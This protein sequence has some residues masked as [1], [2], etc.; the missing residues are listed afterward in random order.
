MIL[1]NIKYRSRYENIHPLFKRGF[2]F[3]EQNDLDQLPNG[4]NEID[5]EN[6]FAIVSRNGNSDNASKL[7]AH[8]KY[9]D[10]HFAL[11]GSDLVGW[12]PLLNCQL[13]IGEFNV[14]DDYILYSDTD[15]MTLPLPVNYFLIVYPEDAHA[16]LL[17]TEN[18][19]K[20]VLKIKL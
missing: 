3:L 18:L 9:I 17:Q 20:I 1:G 12:K 7:E 16:P 8:K 5:G 6:I 10:I 19:F 11:R 14:G 15:F 13:P 2:D 4:K